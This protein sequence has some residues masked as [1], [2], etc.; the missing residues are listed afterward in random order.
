MLHKSPI[1]RENSSGFGGPSRERPP[2]ASLP[3]DPWRQAFDQ[4]FDLHRSEGL[5]ES[6][7]ISEKCLA[8][9]EEPKDRNKASTRAR[10]EEG[11]SRDVWRIT[12][13]DILEGRRALG[14][15]PHW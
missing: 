12:T 4:A 3:R 1:H 8:G 6:L 14:P 7:G 2:T 10:G 11:T 13:Q 15:L 5:G 9:R